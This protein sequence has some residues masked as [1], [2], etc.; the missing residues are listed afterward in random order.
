MPVRANVKHPL[1]HARINDNKKVFLY[2]DVYQNQ[3]DIHTMPLTI[4]D[5]QQV[6]HLARLQLS[7]ADLNKSL[8]DMNSLLGL[9][10]KMNAADTESVSPMA[11]P[12]DLQQPL[13]TD[14][15]TEINQRELF[16]QNAPAVENE[17]YLV[18]TV[19]E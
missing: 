11:H 5:V 7:D 14:E 3:R 19:I 9:V 16:Q 6:A 1:K 10:E 17:L 2:D 18:P 12:Q 15:V 4:K 13:R 8:A